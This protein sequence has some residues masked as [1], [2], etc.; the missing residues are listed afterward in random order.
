MNK[1]ELCMFD[2]LFLNIKIVLRKVLYCIQYKLLKSKRSA[3]NILTSEETIEEIISSRCS[4]CRFGDG[5]ID[6]ITC[7]NE[8]F[9]DSRKSD[10]QIYDENLAQRLKLILQEGSNNKLKL[11]VCIP[12]VWKNHQSFSFVSRRYIERSFVNNR[13]TI[14]TAI[15][16]TRQYGDANFTRFYMDYRDKNKEAYIRRCRQIW[17]GRQLCI[18]EGAQSRLGVGNDLFDNAQS[19]ERILC[20][21]LN[22]FTKYDKILETASCIDKSKLILIALGHTA[23]VLAYDL[24]KIGYQAIDIGHIDIEYEWFL[25]KATKKV[26]IQHKYVNE[27]P[28]GR[29]FSE[30]RNNDY[31]SQIISHI[32]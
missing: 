27:V 11:M 21:A 16:S 9:D 31:I 23:T 25:M 5:E 20:P 2:V 13:N 29:V 6:M 17:Q 15:H 18:I 7:L 4:V 32:Q 30:E 19:I 10:F 28:E 22:A 14:F 1:G 26:P 8:G 3:L 12:Y 24:A